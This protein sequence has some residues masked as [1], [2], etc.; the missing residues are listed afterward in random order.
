MSGKSAPKPEAP[1]KASPGYLLAT[2]ITTIGKSF[3]IEVKGENEDQ[4]MKAA[5]KA[6]YITGRFV[7]SGRPI[8][9]FIQNTV[10]ISV[11]SGG[12]EDS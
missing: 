4:V 6:G 7:P 9:F 2:V 10:G 3:E 5:L 11:R 8:S 1:E 12:R